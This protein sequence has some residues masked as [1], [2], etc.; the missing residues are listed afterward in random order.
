MNPLFLYA[1]VGVV[2]SIIARVWD[3]Y[4]YSLWEYLLNTI[5]WPVALFQLLINL[6]LRIR[7]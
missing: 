2:W 5:L 3:G 6:L 7:L 1:L 4:P